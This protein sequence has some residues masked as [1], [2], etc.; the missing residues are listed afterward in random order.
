MLAL[1]G[2][3]GSAFVAEYLDPSFR[4]PDEVVRCLNVPVLA[5]LPSAIHD[6]IF[7]LSPRNGHGNG[8]GNRLSPPAILGMF[9]GVHGK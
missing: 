1:M 8:N 5:V 3:V 2:G 7:K 6:P 4:A 9:N